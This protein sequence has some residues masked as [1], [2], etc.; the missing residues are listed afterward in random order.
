MGHQEP[1]RAEPL[2]LD[3]KG[4]VLL[5]PSLTTCHHNLCKPHFRSDVRAEHR[6]SSEDTKGGQCSS[7]DGATCY[8]CGSLSHGFCPRYTTVQGPSVEHPGW[9]QGTL[10]EVL[11]DAGTGALCSSLHCS[12][13]ADALSMALL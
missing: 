2:V 7:L 4:F 13:W 3:A 10:V 1:G 5:S 12:C 9:G 6:V 8:P 11:M